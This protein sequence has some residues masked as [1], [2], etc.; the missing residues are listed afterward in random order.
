MVCVGGVSHQG[1]PV[2]EP[3]ALL[4]HKGVKIVIATIYYQEEMLKELKELGVES[5]NIYMFCPRLDPIGASLP[6][7]EE[8]LDERTI[9]LGDFLTRQSFEL[10]CKELTFIGGGSLIMDYMFLKAIAILSGAKEY[11]EVGT[12]IG[13]SI[14]I[15]TECCDKLY[16]VTAGVGEEYSMRNWCKRAKLPDYSERLTYSEKITHYYGDSKKFDFSKHAETVDLYFI[17]GDHSYS[18][19]LSDTQ[20]IFKNKKKNAI[21][22]WHDFKIARNQYNGEVVKAAKD[23]LGDEFKNVYV[24]D[25]N[26]CGIYIP[27]ERLAEFKFRSHKRQFEENAPLYTYDVRLEH[28]QKF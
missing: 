7:L 18:G 6:E 14:N 3:E 9:D 21:V 28:L 13:E 27:P 23:A 4:K 2:K 15:L 8:Q 22:V 5:Q 16:S 25:N 10:K 1:I 17:D 11:L 24:T 20:N 12:Y 26:L 19:V